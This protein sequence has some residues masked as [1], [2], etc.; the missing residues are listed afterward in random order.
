[1]LLH[2]IKVALGKE[3]WR[4]HHI[5]YS[6]HYQTLTEAKGLAEPLLFYMSNAQNP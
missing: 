6:K 3:A 2:Y 1:M 5:S 4:S